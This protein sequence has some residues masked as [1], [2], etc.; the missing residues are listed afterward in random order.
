[1][2]TDSGSVVACCN[3]CCGTA[4]TSS[5]SSRHVVTLFWP[6]AATW[7]SASRPSITYVKVRVRVRGRVLVK[8]KDRVRVKCMVSVSCRSTMSPDAWK[9][10]CPR[11]VTNTVQACR[12]AE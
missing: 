2:A 1:M 10:L 5:A 12:N 3:D 6:A 4:I 8:K 7:H 9:L 11:L